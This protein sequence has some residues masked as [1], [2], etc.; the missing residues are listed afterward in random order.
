MESKLALTAGIL[1]CASVPL[2]SAS[3]Q[4]QDAG[5]SDKGG[6]MGSGDGAM[7]G[8]NTRDGGMMGGNTR[9][10]GMMGGAMM[11]GNTRDGGMMGGGMKMSGEM[12]NMKSKQMAVMSDMM[13]SMGDAMEMQA[14]SIKGPE[15]KARR[16]AMLKIAK[17]AK[18]TS[19]NMRKMSSEMEKLH[20]MGTMQMTPPAEQMMKKCMAAQKEAMQMMQKDSPAD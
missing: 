2:W 10:G 12:M 19:S 6:M 17:D 4:V 3:A 5:R 14:Q 11:G 8:G 13:K 1:F 16:D 20:D 15:M 7:M 18:S 9:D